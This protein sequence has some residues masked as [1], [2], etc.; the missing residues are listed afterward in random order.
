MPIE[1]TKKQG[2]RLSYAGQEALAGYVFAAPWLLHL[3]L[4]TL[5]PL[6]ASFYFS[7]CE[8]QIVKAPVFWG[9][10]N[11]I[12]L[13]TNDRLFLKSLWN[14]L[15]MVL[16]GVPIRM[17]LGMAIALLMNTKVKGRA[18]YRTMYYLPS[19][20]SG[21]AFAM[22]WGFLLNPQFGVVSNA[23]WGLGIKPPLWLA[24]PDWVKPSFILMG[25]WGVGGSM[26]V[27][28]AGLQAIPEVFYEAAEIDGAGR[29]RRFLSITLP[30]LSPTTFFVMTTSIIGTFQIFTQAYVLTAG[31][32]ADASLFYAL[33]LYQQAFQF[34]KMGYASAMAWV[35]FV[36]IM[37]LTLLQL[38]LARS[39]VYYEAV[40]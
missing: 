9:L 19:Q 7:F 5:I 8:Y 4:L 3:L 39:W 11:Y 35:L 13:F 24:D 17:V 18:L 37:G 31:G 38:R 20:V 23:L 25:L 10:R 29:L 21:V 14:T 16:V 34:F 40:R 6:T 28:L 32:P 27:W 1:T 36:I 26:I 15:Y 33:Y 30:L 12:T 22:L 2:R